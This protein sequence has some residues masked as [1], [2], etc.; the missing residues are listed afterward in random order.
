[1]P[2]ILIDTNLLVLLAVGLT[3]RKYISKHKRLA[4]FDESDF[5]LLANYID[6]SH[7]LLFC[8]NVLTEASNLMRYVSEPMRTEISAYFELMISRFG[9]EYVKSA[10]ASEDAAYR[11]LGLTD[12]VLL[13]LAKKDAILL[14]ADLELYLEGAR[15]G[16]PVI[17]YNHMREAQ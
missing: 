9:E 1:M 4:A 5:D 6:Q 10:E 14:T 11:A 12:A 13:T 17:N 16:L 8:P 2:Q 7:G 15:R 3:D